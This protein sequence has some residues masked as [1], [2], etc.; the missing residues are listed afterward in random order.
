MFRRHLDP[1]ADLLQRSG[2]SH[3]DAERLARRG[4]VMQVAAG[5]ALCTKGERGLQA[6]LIL[7]GQAT[8]LTEATTVTI[9]PGEV[10][11][12]LATLDRQRTRNATVVADDDLEVLV[13]DVR[14]FLDLSEDP[15]LRP[16]LV[17]ER[18][19]A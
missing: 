16:L 13:Y 17:P 1:T 18:L 4:T 15:A 14:A 2:L 7:D 8:V 11:G 19:T 6:F 5:T 9:G 3:S 12:E 10:V